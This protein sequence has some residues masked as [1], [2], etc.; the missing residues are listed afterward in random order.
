MG[1]HRSNEV[2]TRGRAPMSEY[3]FAGIEQKEARIGDTVI[4]KPLFLKDSRVMVVF[5]LSPVNRLRELLPDESFVPA[6]IYPGTGILQLNVYEHRDTDI[7][8]FK[9]FAAL[10][11]LRSPRFKNLAGYNYLRAFASHEPYY[12]CL[13][14][15]TSS[16][17]AL[18]T[19]NEHLLLPG[20]LASIEFTDSEGWSTC[21]VKEQGDLIFRLRGRKLR[22]KRSDIN[23]MYIHTPLHP[24]PQIVKANNREYGISLKPSNVELTLG[25]SHPLAG[26]ISGTIRSTKPRILVY[27]PYFQAIFYGPGGTP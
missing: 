23:R 15:G 7:G 13:Q 25:P 5:L 4:R 21:E 17:A 22:A 8:P 10:I 26:K 14:A 12:F 6:Q 3:F 24:Q 27:M 19:F 9:E 1:K 20:M 2:I 18:R 16:E 11:P